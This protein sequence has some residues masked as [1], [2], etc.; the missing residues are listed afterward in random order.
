MFYSHTGVKNKTMLN[1]FFI[2]QIN[3]SS[4][5]FYL[6]QSFVAEKRHGA[7]QKLRKNGHK[8]VQDIENDGYLDAHL[9]KRER[10][11]NK[12]APVL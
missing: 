6:S 3:A 1:R 9:I 12:I 8:S 10:E 4:S 5:C 7:M 2:H 11:M